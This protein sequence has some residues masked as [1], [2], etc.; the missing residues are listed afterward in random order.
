[1]TCA[2]AEEMLGALSLDAL[3]DR[4]RQA[5]ERHVADC[6]SCAA[7]LRAYQDTAARLALA[8]SQQDPPAELKRRVLAATARAAPE[9]QRGRLWPKLG[10]A[11]PQPAALV[12][13]FALAVALSTTIWAAGLQMQLNEQRET[14]AALRE[15]ASRYD[16]VVA[17]LQAP[18]MQ[19]K[20]MQGTNLA[21]E[22]IGRVYVDPQTGAGMMM[23]RSLPPL[24]PGR[25][26]QLWWVRPDGK[27][28]SG[29][30]LTWTDPKGNGY[31]FIQCPAPCN[32]FQAIG[33]TEEPATGSPGP[34]GQRLLGGT[35]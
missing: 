29:G 1:M 28:E 32:G 19:V 13:A 8:M 16:K 11:R 20:P 15:R 24:P 18:D 27:R 5:L 6:P 25:A 31:A 23:V 4:E 26:Y 22:A 17:V 30:L 7:E 3:D 9:R 14:T 2:E 35:L 34:T 21:P 10:F 33:L 12:A